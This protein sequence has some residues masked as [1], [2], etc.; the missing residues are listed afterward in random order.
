MRIN[1][2]TEIVISICYRRTKITQS[3]LMVIAQNTIDFL[4]SEIS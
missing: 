1:V 3:G 4:V 2:A